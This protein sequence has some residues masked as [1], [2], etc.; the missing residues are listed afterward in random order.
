VTLARLGAATG[1]IGR[2]GDDPAGQAMRQSLMDEGVD[3][4]ELQVQ[5]GALS[6]QCIILVDQPT[7]KRS[8]CAYPGTAGEAVVASMSLD[9]ACSGRY[10]HLDG[11]S[12]EA[13]L[14]AARAART[15]GVRVCL[16]AGGS[17]ERLQPLIALTDVLI[18][19]EPFARDAGGGDPERGAALLR[20]FGPA[21]VVA[22]LGAAGSYTA[23]AADA[24]LIPSFPVDVVDTTGA[25]DVFHGAYLFGLLQNWGPR[26]TATFA[27]AAAALKCTKL[28]GRAG[29]PRLEAVNAFLHQR[30][31]SRQAPIGAR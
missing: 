26:E 12:M 21:T 27:N 14:V 18:A 19:N 17:F 3:L 31:H 22:T 28:G 10:L 24:F 6:A 30:G 13:A 20:T 7:G 25:G 4:A 23:T 5:P 29:I 11:F 15:A 9:Y 16:D 2:I 1:Y 8:I